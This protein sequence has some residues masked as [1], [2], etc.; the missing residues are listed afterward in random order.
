MYMSDKLYRD[1]LK[2]VLREEKVFL[3]M[4]Q[5]NRV[6]LPNMMSLVLKSF[7]HSCKVTLAS[8][9]TSQTHFPKGRYS[10]LTY[11]L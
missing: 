8:Y 4:D 6:H 2:Q 5:V 3:R 10:T 9:A 11:V 7:G 1:H